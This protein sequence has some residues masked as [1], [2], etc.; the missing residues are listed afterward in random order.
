[1]HTLFES[2]S[3]K[4]QDLE[5]Y[6][7]DDIERYGLRLGELEKKIV[8]AYRETVSCFHTMSTFFAFRLKVHILQAAGEILEDEGLFEE[9]E[10]DETGALAMCVHSSLKIDLLIGFFFA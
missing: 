8:G 7:F 6:I 4:I 1:M 3:S 2:G 9:E 10:E 5:R